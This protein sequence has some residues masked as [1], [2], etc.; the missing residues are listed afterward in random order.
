MII[1]EAQLEQAPV[2][3]STNGLREARIIRIPADNFSDEMVTGTD[4]LFGT[5]QA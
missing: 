1:T 2:S 3:L 5:N 4:I